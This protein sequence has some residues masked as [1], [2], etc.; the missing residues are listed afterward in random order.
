MT[1]KTC[2]KC[3]VPKPIAEFNKDQNRKDGFYPHCKGCRK[4]ETRKYREKYGKKISE[5]MRA[6]RQNNFKDI[7]FKSMKA[8][9]RKRGIPFDLTIDDIV[10]PERCPVLGIPIFYKAGNKRSNNTPSVD[11]IDNT[12][13][14]TKDNILIVS[15][16]AND[17]KAD[18][19]GQELKTVANFY[20]QIKK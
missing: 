7:L 10:I 14:Y 20:E 11:R 16:R 5:Y 13:G 6:Y 9:S 18:A 3:Q 2:T 17:I 4:N 19:T 1:S 8:R 15:W 12:K